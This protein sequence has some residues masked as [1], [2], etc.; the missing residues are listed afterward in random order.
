MNS[1]L[2]VR[3]LRKDFVF[4]FYYEGDSLREIVDSLIYASSW[5]AI[6]PLFTVSSLGKFQSVNLKRKETS[7]AEL[8]ISIFFPPREANVSR[9]RIDIS[10]SGRVARSIGRAREARCILLPGAQMR[11]QITRIAKVTSPPSRLLARDA[12]KTK[13][14][15]AEAREKKREKVILS[16]IYCARALFIS[17]NIRWLTVYHRWRASHQWGISI[18]LYL[19]QSRLYSAGWLRIEGDPVRLCLSASLQKLRIA[20]RNK[21]YLRET[22]WINLAGSLGRATTSTL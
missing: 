6:F 19:I 7:C 21:R 11:V 5:Y 18:L 14:E 9:G 8:E 10:F 22:R 13:W 1:I 4:F 15:E 3:Y 16:R 12:E 17:R 20:T 2:N